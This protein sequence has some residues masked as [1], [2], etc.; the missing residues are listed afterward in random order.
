MAVYSTVTS[1]T[2]GGGGGAS[3]IIVSNV[4]GIYPVGITES[5]NAF[6]SGGLV[7]SGSNVTIATSVDGSTNY[8]QFT[9]GIG[10][11]AASAGSQSVS[12]NVLV[13]S[14][15][16]GISFGLNASTLT[17]S[18]NAYS[19]TS[20]LTNYLAPKTHIHGS[21][22][23]DLLNLSGATTSAS[24]GLTLGLSGL[25]AQS[26]MPSVI[27]INGASGSLT[28]NAGTFVNISQDI[29]SFTFNVTN[30]SAITTNAQHSSLM[31]NYA[32]VGTTSVSTAG[33]DLAITLNTD[34]LNLGVP[35][36]LTA[37]GTG[38]G[39]ALKGSGTYSQ[40]SGTIEFANSNSMT[41][42][43]TDNQMTASFSYTQSTHDHPYLGSGE[44]T[45]Y[46]TSNLSSVFLTTAAL[47]DHTH[48][49]Y[50]NTSVS[51]NF[52][53][54]GIATDYTSHT[55]DYQSTGAYLTTAAESDHTHDAY[56]NTSISSNFLTT[57]ALSNHTHDQ[58]INTSVSSQ[59][60]TTAANSDHTHSNYVDVSISSQ[61]L[62]TAMASENTSL[63]FY[64]SDSGA[65]Q[66]TSDNSLS[67]GTG[68]T[69]HTHDYAAT[70]H[71]H[72][73]IGRASCRERV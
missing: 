59:W 65:F 61:W 36:W 17:A 45:Y 26:Q 70:D 7:F 72:S 1:N 31:S 3:T 5:T 73:E 29:R 69:T 12:D 46:Q 55:H 52:L 15:S 34:G 48:D 37:G 56:I 66:L 2:S 47:S 71:T 35:A 44:S 25:P 50:L 49:Q 20:Q 16:N 18:H 60:L 19:A 63:F 33:S 51:S 39:A 8:L 4:T 9:A 30:T 40:N 28:F 62:T 32:G 54:E 68:Y 11:I 23:L 42:G 13:F 43:L 53:T 41:F 38:A 24:D 14:N 10:G 27:S 22:S 6:T 58:Y 67:L 21:V 57:A 64:L